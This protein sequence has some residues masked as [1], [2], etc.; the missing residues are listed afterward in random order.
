MIVFGATVRKCLDKG[1]YDPQQEITNSGRFPCLCLSLHRRTQ[2]RWHLCV[3]AVLWRYVNLFLNELNGLTW[4]NEERK[5]NTFCESG[6]CTK[7]DD[8]DAS[9]IAADQCQHGRHD[10]V[11]HLFFDV[12]EVCKS[13]L[14]N[15]HNNPHNPSQNHYRLYTLRAGVQ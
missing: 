5:T 6:H 14:W 12:L 1:N 15:K 8:L 11:R 3:H 10:T 4:T 2:L 9:V 7:C 13:R